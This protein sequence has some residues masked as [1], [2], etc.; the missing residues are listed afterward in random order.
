MGYRKQGTLTL[1]FLAL[2]RE[3]PVR[4]LRCVRRPALA[5]PGGCCR[6][7]VGKLLAGGV[8]AVGVVDCGA[9]VVETGGSGGGSRSDMIETSSRMDVC[10][11]AS[12]W[13]G[14]SQVKLVAGRT[15]GCLVGGRSRPATV[16]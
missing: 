15:V 8:G 4:L 6:G 1:I 13:L 12:D 14:L 9:E 7:G 10:V 5:Y 16:H 2:H 3:H 11:A